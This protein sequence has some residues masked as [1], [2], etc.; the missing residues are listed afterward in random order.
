MNT[1]ISGYLAVSG[2]TFLWGLSHVL[3][4][5]VVAEFQPLA[6]VAF[7]ISCAALLM[8]S[9]Q[10]LRGRFLAPLL[11]QWKKILP[12]AFGGIFVSQFGFILGLSFTSP[13]HGALIY[14]L[15]PIITAV[16][17]FFFKGERL[18]ALQL[19]GIALAFS[20][21]LLLA[22]EGGIDFASNFFIGDMIMF[23]AVIGWSYYTVFSV[24]F[25]K[26]NGTNNTLTAAFVYAVPFAMVGGFLPLIN[27]SI[28]SVSWKG[29][30][31][32]AYLVIGGTVLSVYLFTFSLKH[33]R[34]TTA[35]VFVY[36]QPI[37]A[38]TG[39]FFLLGDAI[40]PRFLLSAGL[41]FAGLSCF[42]FFRRR[43][44]TA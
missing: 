16:L 40:T 39:A 13:S 31:S 36:L 38:S 34:S 9:I 3:T 26:E 24:D 20:G 8:I 5:F 43:N 29:W 12:L 19:S 11:I 7:R 35:A 22:T 32:L 10:K 27:S 6:V 25:I 44:K 18:T 42:T 4:K 33:L 23:C 28:D 2:A 14:T 41:V 21:A 1:R 15:S 17:A 30:S 37:I